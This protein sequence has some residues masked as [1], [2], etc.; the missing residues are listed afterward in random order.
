MIVEGGDMNVRPQSREGMVLELFQEG[1][2]SSGKAAE[3]LGLSQARFLDLLA[4]RNIPY[5]DASPQDLEREL[6]AAKAAMKPSQDVRQRPNSAL[7][8]Y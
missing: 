6:A 4:D 3:I 5:L 1:Q 7:T 8:E 2:I